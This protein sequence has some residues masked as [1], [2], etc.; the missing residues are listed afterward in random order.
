MVFTAKR[1][2]QDQAPVAGSS[3][4]QKQ[5]VVQWTIPWLDFFI[6]SSG[7]HMGEKT[8]LITEFLSTNAGY[9]QKPL[10]EKFKTAQN[11]SAQHMNYHANFAA[12]SVLPFLFYGNDGALSSSLIFF[13]SPERVSLDL[14]GNITIDDVVLG[15]NPIY[16]GHPFLNLNFSGKTRGFMHAN[17]QLTTVCRSQTVV[18][19]NFRD[20]LAFYK[21]N[22]RVYYEG[23]Y[24]GNFNQDYYGGDKRIRNP[25]VYG[26]IGIMFGPLLFKGLFTSGF[27]YSEG[28][29]HTIDY[30]FGFT[31]FE[32]LRNPR[33]KE[34]FPKT[35]FDDYISEASVL[36]KIIGLISDPVGTIS[37][38]F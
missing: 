15:Y 37:S 10:T 18:F 1:L 38:F 5:E 19:R 36:D 7:N 25:S 13:S 9:F 35:S 27:T 3:P 16:A 26:S 6:D 23:K 22:G 17:Y 4:T 28:L 34:L 31:A 8:T 11:H 12:P 20:I 2:E 24:E 30:N 29:K 14:E 21:L 33:F 32:I